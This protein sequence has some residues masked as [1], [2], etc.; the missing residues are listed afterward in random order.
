MD[1]MSLKY[2]QKMT[3]RGIMDINILKKKSLC[4]YKRCKNA[5]KENQKFRE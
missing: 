1:Y 4:N 5:R 3:F 2:L